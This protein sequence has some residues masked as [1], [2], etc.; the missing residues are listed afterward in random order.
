[1]RVYDL[2]PLRTFQC[3]WA[4]HSRVRL[5]HFPLN[6][7]EI[8]VKRG[9]RATREQVVE[10]RIEVY[11]ELTANLNLQDASPLKTSNAVV[12]WSWRW[13]KRKERRK[14]KSWEI[15]EIVKDYH[16]FSGLHILLVFIL[17]KFAASDKN[18][19]IFW[20]QKMQKI[21]ARCA[22][23]NSSCLVILTPI[24][25][26]RPSHYCK[27]KHEL[28]FDSRTAALTWLG[29]ANPYNR[30][31]TTWDNCGAHVRESS[32]N[33]WVPVLGR[34]KELDEYWWLMNRMCTF[35]HAMVCG[36]LWVIS[37]VY[38]GYISGSVKDRVSW[39]KVFLRGAVQEFD[40]IV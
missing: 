10:I 17:H 27:Q 18:C 30:T 5:V 38:S 4:S 12:S 23:T 7:K 2:L 9:L 24:G 8:T 16:D 39:Y 28:V 33:S 11:L 31:P 6:W 14:R 26:E 22:A 37:I 3:H 35:Y 29:W 1:M 32:I 20:R 15:E 25:R 40:R 21:A 34:R 19:I 13:V 36:Y